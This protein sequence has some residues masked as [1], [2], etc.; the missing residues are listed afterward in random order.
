MKATSLEGEV[1]GVLRLFAFKPR[2]QMLT[3]GIKILPSEDVIAW[4]AINRIHRKEFGF[5]EFLP[6]LFWEYTSG[7][8]IEYGDDKSFWIT[9]RLAKQ[10]DGW[11]AQLKLAFQ[12]WTH[13]YIAVMKEIE[14]RLQSPQ[15]S[16]S[17]I[18]K[19]MSGEIEAPEGLAVGGDLNT[20]DGMNA[21]GTV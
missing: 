20:V 9:C 5:R 7:S 19:L 12:P 15:P 14:R 1:F 18:R 2:F 17:F 21:K 6:V 11:Q 3:A 13:T 4:S 8:L 10:S 16:A